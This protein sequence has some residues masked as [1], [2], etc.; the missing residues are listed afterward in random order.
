MNSYIIKV[1]ETEEERDDGISN[2][3]E[4]GIKSIS[5]AIKKAQD[6]MEIQD[7]AS[8]EV[9]NDS[10]NLTFYF[11]T[12]NE[13]EYFYNFQEMPKEDR[14]KNIV[15]MYF[16]EKQ[17]YN[18]MDYGSDRDSIVMTSL[19]DFYKELLY[20]LDID[21][22]DIKTEDISDGK[23][24]TTIALKNGNEINVDT[25]AWNGQE[26]IVDN[27]KSIQD[28]YDNSIQNEQDDMEI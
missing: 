13:E 3:I 22:Y 25:S 16:F 27:L 19:S 17:M 26:I 4:V 5:E 14:I 28:F 2:I 1:W 8:L 10:E 23:Y 7:Y 6:Y 15:E 11:C 24:L 20:K 18:L 21:F 12:P 9:Q